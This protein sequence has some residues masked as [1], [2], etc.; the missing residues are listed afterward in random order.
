MSIKKQSAMKDSMLNSVSVVSQKGSSI[1]DIDRLCAGFP[2]ISMK[3]HRGTASRFTIGLPFRDECQS[4]F[5]LEPVQG[6]TVFRRFHRRAKLTER[7]TM[8]VG[9]GTG[10]IASPVTA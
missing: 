4:V 10:A 8:L 7:R 9:S 1:H 3:K 2:L 5:L 6:E